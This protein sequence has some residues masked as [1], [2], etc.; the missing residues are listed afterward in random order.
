MINNWGVCRCARCGNR[1][2]QNHL[3]KLLMKIRDEKEGRDI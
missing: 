2:D 1:Q 3:G